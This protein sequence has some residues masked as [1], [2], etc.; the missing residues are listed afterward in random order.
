[1]E[2]VVGKSILGGKKLSVMSDFISSG[3]GGHMQKKVLEQ[4]FI[5][6]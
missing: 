3:V 2:I 1:M 6:E 4:H 5:R